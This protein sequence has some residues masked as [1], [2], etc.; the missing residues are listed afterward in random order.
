MRLLLALARYTGRR[1]NAL[2]NLRASDVLLSRDQMV[3]ALAEIGAPIACA[4]QWAR[5]ALRFSAKFDKRG[6]ESVVPLSSDARAAIDV[7]LRRHPKAGDVPLLPSN[8]EPHLACGKIFA[9]RW[10]RRAEKLAELPNIA[11]GAWHPF[12]RSVASEHRHLPDADIMVAGWRSS[13]V[14]RESYQHAD[15]QGMLSVAEPPE[16][17]PNPRESGTP[18]AQS[19][20][21]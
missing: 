17:R 15:G 19:E 5:G 8:T 3:T 14:M 20:A 2:S 6:C 9:G 16:S 18:V 21:K 7:Y 12:R 10:L 1:I 4:D 11:R 13:R